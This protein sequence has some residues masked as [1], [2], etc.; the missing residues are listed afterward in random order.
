MEYQYLFPIDKTCF[1]KNV[2]KQI[3]QITEIRIRVYRPILIY[4]NQK[5]VSLDT[6][7]EFI[8]S[9]EKGYRFEYNDLQKL[10]DFWC[11]DSRYAFQEEMKKGFFTMKGGHRIGIC[12][13]VV[14]DA[15]GNIQAIKYI[16]SINIRIAHE[17][18]GAANPIINYIYEKSKVASTLIIS[19]PGMGKTT[20]L[21][22]IIRLLSNG[23]EEK[24]GKNVALVDE[25]GEIAACY[26]GVPQLDVGSRT[27]VLFGCDKENGMKM[28]LQSMSPEVIA[29]DELITQKE[30]EM[31]RQMMGRG[32]AVIATMHG[33]DMIH[34][35]RYQKWFE[36]FEI[37][38]FLSK[39][40]GVFKTKLYKL[41]EVE[42]CKKSWE[43]YLLLP[44]L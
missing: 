8:Y 14:Y 27:D 2:L 31:I 15:K 28:L 10:I 17:I 11:M 16:S 4:L 18:K 43:S 21:R 7:G 6:N 44:D 35:E 41:E 36:G 20:L 30:R 12:G 32:C 34:D 29:V 40:N 23:T 33:E 26:Q 38:L 37:L 19:P 3:D 25:R 42:K 39:Q 13:E 1:W 9:I 22:D 24:R 5:E